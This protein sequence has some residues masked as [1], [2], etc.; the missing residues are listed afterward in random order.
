MA[1]TGR[2]ASRRRFAQAAL[3]RASYRHDRV[4]W[5]E[6]FFSAEL[7][8]LVDDEWGPIALSM[9]RRLTAALGS[10]DYGPALRKISLIP[11][12][13]RPEWQ[14]GRRERRLFKR[15]ESW[16]DYR[17]WIDFNG[18]REG[19]DKERERLLARNLVEAIADLGRKAGKSFAADALIA[20]VL[21]T[22]SLKQEDID[23]G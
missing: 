10:R 12:I 15:S 19:D 8:V 13:L 7:D 1:V 20:D 3:Q 17:T 6:F 16:A 5:M 4:N 18:F 2:A 14:Q 23:R 21:D 11:M 22:L 9:E